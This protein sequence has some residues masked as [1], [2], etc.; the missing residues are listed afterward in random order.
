MSLE[1]DIHYIHIDGFCTQIVD[2][3]ILRMVTIATEK[4]VRCTA[5][6]SEES[7][8]GN[9]YSCKGEF[10]Q[11]SQV[12]SVCILCEKLIFIGSRSTCWVGT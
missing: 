10:E 12:N 4:Q 8:L 5:S 11:E 7:S 1:L 6:G 9:E 3:C 2:K